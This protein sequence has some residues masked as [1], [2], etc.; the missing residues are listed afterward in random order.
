M[1]KFWSKRWAFVGD[2]GTWQCTW[3]RLYLQIWDHVVISF[4]HILPQEHEKLSSG[5]L[6]FWFLVVLT[7]H[8]A[9]NCTASQRQPT[10]FPFPELSTP[11]F[12]KNTP[13]V[14]WAK[15][16]FTTGR[17]QPDIGRKRPR[18]IRCQ[19]KHLAS[20]SL[21][22]QGGVSSVGRGTSGGGR[23]VSGG[24]VWA[25]WG[26]IWGGGGASILFKLK[27]LT[28]QTT[29]CICHPSDTRDGPE[30]HLYDCCTQPVFTKSIIWQ[31][32]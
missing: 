9:L 5:I 11:N 1:L 10:K 22:G 2:Y 19:T 28:L 21:K 25:H 32:K 31:I 23:V 29:Q 12:N 20:V 14:E 16:F 4:C 17:H 26:K 15:S 13:L 18:C 8:Q 3:N 30:S 6:W 7:K 24:K 27:G